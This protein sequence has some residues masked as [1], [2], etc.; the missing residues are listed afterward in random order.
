MTQIHSEI[1]EMP[2][3][4]PSPRVVPDRRQTDRRGPSRP[5]IPGAGERERRAPK[6]RRATPRLEVELDCEERVDGGRFFRVT[7][8]LSTFGLSTRTGHPHELGTRLDLL[9]YL[10]DEPRRPVRVTAEVVGWDNEGHGM[11]LAFRNPE[12]EAVR[13]IHAYLRTKVKAQG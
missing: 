13:R 6:E 11:R 1:N 7:R 10:P 5:P 12:K 9:L 8:D 4:A 3:I 2:L